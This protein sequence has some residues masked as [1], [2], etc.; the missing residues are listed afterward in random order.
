M[1]KR[2]SWIENAVISVQLRDDLHTLAQMRSNHLI[3]FFDIR[4]NG[5]WAG[6]DLSTIPVLFCV[7]VAEQRL[8]PLF[9]RTLTSQEA[10]PNSRP[11]LRRMLSFIVKPGGA[12]GAD[13]VELTEAYSSV[14]A[15]VIKAD[16]SVEENLTEIQ[17]YE[18]TGM[19]GDAEK[20][21]ARLIRYFDTGVNWDD[22]KSFLFP[23]ITLP[24]PERGEPC[25]AHQSK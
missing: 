2:I 25:L 21:K 11:V 13:L 9:K 23:S 14:N 1:T 17:K 12:F 6:I 18:L 3:E 16:L 10:I 8:R 20:L 24:S 7:Y 4:G 5:D 22:S 15:T 19:V